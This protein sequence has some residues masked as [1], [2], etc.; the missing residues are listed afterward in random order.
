MDRGGQWLAQACPEESS[1][2]GGLLGGEEDASG[3]SKLAQR[4]N[5]ASS[6]LFPLCRAS[7]CVV[8][9]SASAGSPS[10]HAALCRWQDS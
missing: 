2:H 9:P 8:C 6:S 1:R 5:D 3:H 10:H 7:L 4:R